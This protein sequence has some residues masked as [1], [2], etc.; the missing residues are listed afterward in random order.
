MK[1][2]SEAS[3]A[4]EAN[5]EA[6]EAAFEAGRQSVVDLARQRIEAMRG[7]AEQRFQTLQTQ[8]EQ[9]RLEKERLLRRSEEYIARV[10]EEIAGQS[11][12]VR[13][14]RSGMDDVWKKLRKEVDLN[15]LYDGGQVLGLLRGVLQ[16]SVKQTL[17]QHRL[18]SVST[19]PA[20]AQQQQQ[21]ELESEKSSR[22]RQHPPK[23]EMNGSR[24]DKKAPARK[25][26]L[27]GDEDLPDFLDHL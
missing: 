24:G 3:D 13:L 4:K 25:E 15:S 5:A 26:H 16:D 14:L 7:V 27:S 22:S 8:L 10:Q 19:T 12:A 21:Q 1:S 11:L 17:L 9:E 18:S 2:S 23:K 6:L 20:A